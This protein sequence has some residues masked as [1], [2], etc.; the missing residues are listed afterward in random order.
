[1]DRGFPVVLA[2]PCFPLLDQA[3]TPT[4]V[5]FLLAENIKMSHGTPYKKATA[6]MRWKWKKK[7]T[8]R[9]QKKRRKMRARAK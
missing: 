6:K 3:L 5:P 9:L 8:R 1:M 2:L 7:R 4:L